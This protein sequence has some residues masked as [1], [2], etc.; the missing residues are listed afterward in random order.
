LASKGTIYFNHFW[1]GKKME[2]ENAGGVLSV[3]ATADLDSGWQSIAIFHD[4]ESDGYVPT[5]PKS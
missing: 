1:R 5:Q 4:T 2:R 3:P